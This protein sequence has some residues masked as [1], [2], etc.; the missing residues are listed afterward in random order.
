M[1]QLRQ[2][3]GSYQNISLD[4]VCSLVTTT[5]TLDDLN[6][7]KPTTTER[8]VF[9][10]ISSVNRAEFFTAGKNGF[11]PQMIVY[12]QAEEYDDQEELI[13]RD[14]KY[15]I[16]RSFVRTDGYVELSC[17]KRVGRK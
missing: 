7:Q 13:Y 10:M 8:H 3:T 9:C 15:F 6:Q 17:E 5:Y 16:Y 12:M 2:R 11:K 1:P 14:H 4:D